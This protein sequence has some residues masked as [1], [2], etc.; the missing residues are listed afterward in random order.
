MHA[1]HEISLGHLADFRVK[2]RFYGKDEGGRYNLPYQGLRSDL[3]C[4]VKQLD[5]PDLLVDIKG[6]S[7]YSGLSL[8]NFNCSMSSMSFGLA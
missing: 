7:S 2:Y 5:C 1:P 6:P 8:L 4:K 3:L